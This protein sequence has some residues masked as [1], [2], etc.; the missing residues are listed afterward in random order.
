MSVG[1]FATDWPAVSLQSCPFFPLLAMKVA[2]E[3]GAPAKEQKPP[4]AAAETEAPAAKEQKTQQLQRC[5]YCAEEYSPAAAS[6]GACPLCGQVDDSDCEPT[7]TLENTSG[8]ASAAATAGAETAAQTGA[9]GAAPRKHKTGAKPA[10]GAKRKRTG[11]RL[12]GILWRGRR[13]L[14][15]RLED[16][17]SGH[18]LEC[19]FPEE[20]WLEVEEEKR[21]RSLQERAEQIL[22]V[23]R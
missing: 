19:P 17:E 1:V 13:R 12:K 8:A 23:K 9:A 21:Q 14:K 5:P 11:R 10:A 22:R 7:E 2:A 3:T 6:A 4:A 18:T 16:E 20:F 15:R